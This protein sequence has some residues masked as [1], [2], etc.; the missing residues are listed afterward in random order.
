MKLK[1][2]KTIA[3]FCVTIFVLFNISTAFAATGSVNLASGTAG[4]T[5]HVTVSGN[6]VDT[7]RPV[8]II[9]SDLSMG[10]GVSALSIKY[11]NQVKP[12]DLGSWS[13]NFDVEG[14]IRNYDIKVRQDGAVEDVAWGKVETFTD[15]ITA[16]M[17]AYELDNILNIDLSVAN[18]ELTNPY[19]NLYIAYYDSR[20]NFIEAEQ[21]PVDAVNGTKDFKE[22]YTRPFLIGAHYAKVFFWARNMI[23]LTKNTDVERLNA[24]PITFSLPENDALITK[25]PGKGWIRYTTEE[26]GEYAAYTQKADDYSE[27]AYTRFTWNALEPTE[28]NYDWSPIENGIEKYGARGMKFSFGVM[29]MDTSTARPT[30]PEWVFNAGAAHVTDKNGIKQPQQ[31]DDVYMAKM[32]NF[33]TALANKYDGDTRIEFIDIRSYGNY[34]EFHGIYAPDGYTSLTPEQKQAHIDMYA[35]AFK[36]TQ[37]ICATGAF[38]RNQGGYL[39][40]SYIINSGVGIRNDAAYDIQYEV[41][42][43]HGYEPA[44]SELAPNYLDFKAKYGFNLEQ[45]L[46][47]V[48]E[49][50][51]SY[52]DIGE[53]GNSSAAFVKEQE[54]VIKYLTNKLGYHLVATDVTM[55][56]LAEPGETF[57]VNIGW[58]NKGIT[59]LYKDAVIDVALL[60]KDDKVVATFR[61]TANPAKT[62]AP[63]TP[64]DDKVAVTMPDSLPSGNYKLAVGIGLN[65]DGYQDDKVPDL[66]IGNYGKTAD[67]WYVFANVQSKGQIVTF[68]PYEPTIS[69]Q[70]DVS[71]SENISASA[72]ETT[73]TGFTNNSGTLTYTGS[74]AATAYQK[75]EVDSDYVYTLGFTADIQGP[76]T[77]KFVDSNGITMTSFIADKNGSNSYSV[78]FDC[79]DL[80]TR[81]MGMDAFRNNSVKIVF[82]AS[83][84]TGSASI[85]GI[86]ISNSAYSNFTNGTLYYADYGAETDSIP[87]VKSTSKIERTTKYAHTGTHSYAVTIPAKSSDGNTTGGVRFKLTEEEI[88]NLATGDYKAEVYVRTDDGVTIDTVKF[89]PINFTAYPGGESNV[90]SA[91]GQVTKE[92]FSG[93]WTKLS[94][95]SEDG[96]SVSSTDKNN[97]TNNFYD[98][99]R[100]TSD[101]TEVCLSISV[102][103]SLDTPVTLY[104]DDVKVTKR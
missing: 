23:P 96:F 27:T 34:G 51:F 42:H 92:N 48:K 91:L 63:D 90:G 103:N 18:P 5:S 30:T 61:S 81:V 28:G 55:P 67:K 75:I 64:V 53:W 26:G 59:Y 84:S 102:T 6:V 89:T 17:F 101:T 25:N 1:L 15:K 20:D 80:G 12:S 45:Y 52:L 37:L 85:S 94:S 29:G 65:G 88:S 2:N 40:S 43:F 8:N 49:G 10:V 100:R 60:D 73:G 76:V 54:P 95:T 36:K 16:D 13:F 41:A 21:I 14:D 58:V 57:N 44:V 38:Y 99:G 66:E 50:K 35:D 82:E 19:C 32:K 24:E 4:L 70:Q 47:Y 62:W 46:E 31:A 7:T 33:V 87:Y 98:N 11:V 72:W 93:G 71:Y 74:S 69:E 39:D 56:S 68:A 104:F 22:T 79:Y 3:I 78:N 86:S 83:A 97:M 9:V 77:V